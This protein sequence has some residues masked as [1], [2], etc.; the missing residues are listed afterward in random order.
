MIASFDFIKRERIFFVMFVLRVLSYL[1]Q[2]SVN[3]TDLGVL[4]IVIPVELAMKNKV[5]K[6][7]YWNIGLFCMS[8]NFLVI[9]KKW[10]KNSIFFFFQFHFETLIF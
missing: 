2:S 3:A 1:N 9:L 8:E 5:L 10:N 4:L 6:F 7:S